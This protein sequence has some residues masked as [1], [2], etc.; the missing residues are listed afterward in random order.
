[1]TENINVRSGESGRA[2]SSSWFFFWLGAGLIAGGGEMTLN[3]CFLRFPVLAAKLPACPGVAIAANCLVYMALWVMA[4]FLVGGLLELVRRAVR[5]TFSFHIIAAA[6]ALIGGVIYLAYGIESSDLGNLV[7]SSGLP[8]SYRPLIPWWW[9]SVGVAASLIDGLLL[10]LIGF[11]RKPRRA[12]RWLATLALAL[13]AFN[14]LDHDLSRGIPRW[15]LAAFLALLAVLVGTILERRRIAPRKIVLFT[16]A[17]ALLASGALGIYFG[18]PGHNFDGHI[19]M[20]IWDAQRPDRM[21]V[22]GYNRAT[23]PTLSAWKE[24][25]ISFRR[26]YSPA[27]YTFASHVSVFT[28]RYLREHHLD[29]GT[30]DERIA[31]GTYDTLAAAMGRKGFHP[32]LLTEN[33]WL[34]Q[35]GK[36][37]KRVINCPTRRESPLVFLPF[38]R[39]SFL[40]LQLIDHL[41]FCLEGLFKHTVIRIED[42]RLSEWILRARREGPYF[43]CLNWMFVHSRYYPGYTPWVP[44]KEQPPATYDAGTEYMDYRLGEWIDLLKNARQ[45]DRSLFLVTADHGDF[46]GEFGLYGHGKTLLEPVL[47]VPL[48]LFGSS[49]SPA[50]VEKPVPLVALKSALT[51]LSSA[52]PGGQWNIPAFIENMVNNRGMIVEGSYDFKGPGNSLRWFLAAWDGKYKYI[53]DCH[54]YISGGSSG[55]DLTGFAFLYDLENDPSEKNNLVKDRPDL[56]SRMLK[57]ISDW[58]MRLEPVPL[59]PLDESDAGEYPPGLI[60]QLRALGYVR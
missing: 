14:V 52:P 21:S 60:N 26:A 22:Y 34:I 20:M 57:L 41:P 30:E 16:V 28:G 48:L 40:A 53:Q 44:L 58:E 51:A 49:V 23:T 1:M 27:N 36:G 45:L 13:A 39:G 54:R 12:A 3:A 37:F 47:H 6:I 10:I 35:L 55:L 5:A 46:L 59:P 15:L 7:P 29:N 19:I 33:P 2:G 43:I 9:L 24:N 42:R 25:M 31:Y 17:T 38:Y 32:L 11:P 8:E 56:L 18:W 50:L 4:S